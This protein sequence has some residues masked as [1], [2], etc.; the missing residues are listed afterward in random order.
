MNMKLPVVKR[1]RLA[2][3]MVTFFNK[4]DCPVEIGFLVEWSLE[5][6]YNGQ[7][8]NEMDH[9]GV[10]FTSEKGTTYQVKCSTV[11]DNSSYKALIKKTRD[12]DKI[13]LAYADQK[14]KHIYYTVQ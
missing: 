14:T 2:E 11:G 3:D 13:I 12:V 10:D 6:I 8:T 9:L 7:S 5:K 4:W 1:L